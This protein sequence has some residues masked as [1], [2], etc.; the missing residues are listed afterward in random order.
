MLNIK[1]EPA[2]DT[3]SDEYS[4]ERAKQLAKQHIVLHQYTN[5]S[6]LK[7]IIANRSLRFTRM[8]QL[9]DKTENSEIVDLWKKKVYV[10]CFTH[11][12]NESYFFWRTYTS[13][14][15][16]GIM[17]SFR[18]EYL[19]DLSFYP[20]EICAQEAFSKCDRSNYCFD[21]SLAVDASTLGIYDY[22]CVDVMY[23]PRTM[24]ISKPTN[25]QGRFKYL[26][27]DSECETRLRLALKPRGKEFKCNEKGRLVHP[28][29]N[30]Q[31]IY[32]KLPDICLRTMTITLSPFANE[33]LKSWVE[34]LLRSNGLHDSVKVVPSILT[35]EVSIDDITK[36][37][38]C[39][40]T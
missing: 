2:A 32:A 40:S 8:D 26:E 16:D 10:S 39:P 21:A 3:A 6:A 30:N 33:N 24:C 23:V 17:L 20:D 22:S 25:H 28:F 4:Y 18:S 14:S 37:N 7:K 35:N 1:I 34:H 31:H 29:P 11:R 15:P 5:F 36:R 27:W 19:Y 13:R 38:F 12:E 9:N